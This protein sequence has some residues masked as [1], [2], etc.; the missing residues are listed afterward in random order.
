MQRILF[1]I[2]IQTLTSLIRPPKIKAFKKKFPPQKK[3]APSKNKKRLSR[4]PLS[5]KRNTL[6]EIKSNSSTEKAIFHL[7]PY[8]Q[9]LFPV[10]PVSPR[11]PIIP[12]KLP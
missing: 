2:A 7:Q 5:P 8:T 6:G 3:T 11:K 4:F 10:V 1:T 12:Q 9:C